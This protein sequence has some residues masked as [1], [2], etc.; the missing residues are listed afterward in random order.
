MPHQP[1]ENAHTER[2]EQNMKDMYVQAEFT[3]FIIPQNGTLCSL[4]GVIPA[5][6]LGKQCILACISHGDYMANKNRP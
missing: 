4:L 5:H 3:R 1:Q 2:I 6:E